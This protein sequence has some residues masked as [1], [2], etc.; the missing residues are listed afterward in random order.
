M[1][2]SHGWGSENGHLLVNE[3]QF[4][5]LVEQRLQRRLHLLA[6]WTAVIEEL[7]NGDV[8]LRIA[9]HRRRRV[10]KDL[11]AMIA[12]RLVRLGIL[13][14]PQRVKQDVG[15]LHH[16]VVNDRLDRLALFGGKLGGCDR[17]KG[18]GGEECAG[19]G[20]GR[21]WRAVRHVDGYSRRERVRTRSSQ[22]MDV[23]EAAPRIFDMLRLEMDI[24]GT[25]VAGGVFRQ[26]GFGPEGLL[27]GVLL[28]SAGKPLLSQR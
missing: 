24:L 6:I 13:G 20:Q 1:G 8:A 18:N 19:Q 26:K 25:V 5:I 16:I 15:M 10:I 23:R 9:P 17:T 3:T 28:L 7:D 14:R 22:S 2:R 12:E 4:T 11:M 27:L 21:K